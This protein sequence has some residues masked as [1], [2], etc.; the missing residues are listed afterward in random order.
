MMGCGI[1]SFEPQ[2]YVS[3]FYRPIELCNFTVPRQLV[4]EEKRARLKMLSVVV[5]VEDIQVLTHGTASVLE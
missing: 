5:V 1:R 4:T 3:C 2:G